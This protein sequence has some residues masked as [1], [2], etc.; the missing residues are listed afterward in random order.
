[1]SVIIRPLQTIIEYQ[2]AELLQQAVWGTIER[3]LTPDH[4]MITAQ[5]NG[6]VVLGAFD[7]TV[8]TPAHLVGWLFGFVGLHVDGTIKQCSHQLGILPAYQSQRLGYQMKCAQREQVLAQG[9]KLITWTFDPLQS[10]N[11]YLNLN[12][13]GVICNTYL[14][15]IYG[16]MQDGLNQGLTSDRFEVAWHLESNRVHS[17]LQ[18]SASSTPATPLRLATL[19]EAGV[20]LLNRVPPDAGPA[21]APITQPLEGPRLLVQVPYDIQTVKDAGVA[22]AIA[23]RTQIRDLFMRAFAAGYIVTDMVVEAQQSFYLLE[24]HWR[25]DENR[26]G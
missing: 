18:Q 14:Q 16:E 4:V 1:M 10:R 7:P 13:L 19:L 24:Q 8:D 23:W 11:A 9:V 26:T 15:N 6:G 25:D 2:A 21:P 5:K 22:H 12:K 17:R 20:P 3:R